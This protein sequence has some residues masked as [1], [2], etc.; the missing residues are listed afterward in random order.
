MHNNQRTCRAEAANSKKITIF[1]P[2]NKF[3][4]I[5]TDEEFE[6]LWKRVKQRDKEKEAAWDALPEEEKKRRLAE[7]SDP[8]FER[9]T[10][11]ITGGHDDD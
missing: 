9:I 1:A 2:T 7:M 8:F 11:D 4:V 10:D 3:A 5:M 6:T